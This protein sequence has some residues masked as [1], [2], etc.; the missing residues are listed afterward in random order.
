MSEV[1]LIP[2]DKVSVAFK[3]LEREGNIVK[4]SPITG[5]GEFAGGQ[6]FQVFGR[7]N[8]EDAIIRLKGYTFTTYRKVACSGLGPH[9]QNHID[10][11][12]SRYRKS[13]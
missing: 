5:R 8:E 2:T 1:M 4:Y 3:I 10:K 11:M 9:V 12:I 7:A 6:R 13:A